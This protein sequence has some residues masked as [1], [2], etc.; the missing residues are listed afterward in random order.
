MAGDFPTNTIDIRYNSDTYGPFGFDFTDVLPSGITVSS[1]VVRAFQGTLKKDDD[2]SDFTE[3]TTELIVTA[4]TTVSSPNV[5]V[6]FDYP[7]ATYTNEKYTLV[8]E[9]TLSNSAVHP[10][11]FQY[12]RVYGEET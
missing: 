3:V 7:T 2:L 6:Y 12:V 8:F 4:S 9:L 5:Y 11:Y 10:L 1:A